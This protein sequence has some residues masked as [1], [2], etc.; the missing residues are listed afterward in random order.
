VE[1]LQLHPEE[2]GLDLVEA[3]VRPGFLVHVLGFGSVVAKLAQASGQCIVARDD[4]AAVAQRAEVLAGVEA[5]AG[6]APEGSGWLSLEARA[7]RLRGVLDELE[8]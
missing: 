5:E 4:G 7:V 8:A 6:G 3:G 2:G 1:A